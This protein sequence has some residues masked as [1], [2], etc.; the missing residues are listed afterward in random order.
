M[1]KSR[2]PLLIIAVVLLLAFPTLADRRRAPKG[3][4]K[5]GAVE[6]LLGDDWYTAKTRHCVA[7]AA[8]ADLDYVAPIV[9]GLDRSYDVNADFVG[10]RARG[11]LEFYFFPMTDPPHLHP[12]F[13]RRVGRS[14]KFAGLALSGTKVC[15]INLGNQQ[16]ARPYSPWEV[17]STARH[18]MNHL[19]AFQKIRSRGWSWFLEAIAENIEQTVNPPSSQ[20]DVNAYKRYLKGYRSQD[21][22][23]A[24][25]TAERNND[26]V[27]GYREFGDILSSV[28]SFM[29]TKYGSDS[30]AKVLRA[31]PGKTPDE[32]FKL[33][34]NK[35]V[36]QLEAEWKKF[37]GIR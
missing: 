5:V 19:F 6:G 1:S 33:V 7:F 13:Q 23:W 11:P 20:M 26:N 28:V 2:L 18:E 24:A 17:E 31:A 15:L 25:L 8:G 16:Q 32:A 12:R 10:F 21:A 29:Q 36:A 35:D 34:F 4:T 22:S 30:V 9:D 3:W 27:E 14:S 37:Y